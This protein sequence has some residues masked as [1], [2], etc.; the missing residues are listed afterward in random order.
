MTTTD[1]FGNHE[2]DQLAA[3][4][5][6]FEACVDHRGPEADGPC[7]ECGWLAA[8]HTAGLAEVIEVTRA[9]VAPALRR[10]S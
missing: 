2:A 5:G 9:A 7:A 8:D 4:V 10:A 6:R 3:A 1:T